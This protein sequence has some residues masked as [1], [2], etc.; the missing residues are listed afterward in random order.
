MGS[1]HN[2]GLDGARAEAP[3]DVSGVG[4]GGAEGEGKDLEAEFTGHAADRKP[5]GVARGGDDLGWER[6]E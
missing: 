2:D 1:R 6:A 5:I 4:P 3:A